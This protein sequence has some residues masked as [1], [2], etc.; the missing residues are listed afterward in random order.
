MLQTIAERYPDV[1]VS[2]IGMDIDEKSCE[3]ARE[4]LGSVKNVEVEIIVEDYQEIDPS[5]FNIPPCDLVL[6]IHVFY[7]MKDI[8]KALVDTRKFRKQDG[9]CS[10]C[11]AAVSFIKLSVLL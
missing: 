8:T 9:E 1:K 7:Y 5:K 10:R 3:Q 11:D 2:Y 6:A 4:L